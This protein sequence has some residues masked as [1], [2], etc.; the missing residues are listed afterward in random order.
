[1]IGDATRDAALAACSRVGEV[2]AGARLRSGQSQLPLAR[3]VGVTQ[4]TWSS[5]ELGSRWR[6]GAQ[7][8]QP[9]LPSRENLDA[10]VDL[11]R[12]DPAT[13]TDL[14]SL[15]DSACLAVKTWQAEPRPDSKPCAACKTTKPLTEF[16]TDRSRRLGVTPDCK[17]CRTARTSTYSKGTEKAKVRRR[18]SSRR[19]RFSEKYGI[20]PEEYD[21]MHAEQGGRCSIC[22]R[23][24][25]KVDRH[26]TEYRLAVD[27]DHAT[28]R[29]RS[30]L[31]SLCNRGIGYLGDEP[32]RLRLA[33][34][35]IERHRDATA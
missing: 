31:C 14:H 11:L 17:A 8:R 27:H 33:A 13:V 4:A 2:L 3:A 20:T 21:V 10:A 12:L 19:H 5:W 32:A 7:P 23:P 35:Y 18:A 22:D 1:M 26:G 16:F 30:L 28:G 15:Y 34:A 24:E 25:S 6:P 9:Y 29:V